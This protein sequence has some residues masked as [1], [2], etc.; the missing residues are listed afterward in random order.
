MPRY[1]ANTP[2]GRDIESVKLDGR[3]VMH[4]LAI[5]TADTD[6]GWLDVYETYKGED[7]R[8]RLKMTEWKERPRGGF[9]RDPIIT[10]V[11]GKVEVVLG[12][13]ARL[14]PEPKVVDAGPGFATVPMDVSSMDPIG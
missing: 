9:G 8:R 1:E 3:E 4:E 11:Y 12:R 10:R 13:M 6:E 14:V 5:K 7:G 2:E